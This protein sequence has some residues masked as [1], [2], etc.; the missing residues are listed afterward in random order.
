[1]FNKMFKWIK[2]RFKGAK[3]VKGGFDMDN[4]FLIL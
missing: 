2:N 4:P 1:M 3:K